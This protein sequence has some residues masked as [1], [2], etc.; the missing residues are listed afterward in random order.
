M[1]NEIFGEDIDMLEER[2]TKKSKNKIY[3]LISSLEQDENSKQIEGLS[4]I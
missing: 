1:A 3:D 2:V 4:D